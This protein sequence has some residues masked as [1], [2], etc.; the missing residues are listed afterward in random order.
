[1]SLVPY[2]FIHMIV[3]VFTQKEKEEQVRGKEGKAKIHKEKWGKKKRG[4]GEIQMC[5][6][7]VMNKG[8]L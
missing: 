4:R 7:S 6:S 8:Y 5:F 3:L 2:L 1:M